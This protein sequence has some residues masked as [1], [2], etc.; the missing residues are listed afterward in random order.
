MKK[1]QEFSLVY[2][3][4]EELYEKVNESYSPLQDLIKWCQEQVKTLN[5]QKSNGEKIA[6]LQEAFKD[7]DEMMTFMDEK[8]NEIEE[9]VVNAD[10]VKVNEI[11]EVLVTVRNFL[12]DMN[13]MKDLNLETVY[14]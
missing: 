4:V 1:N 14:L 3:D 6:D 8:R 7:I 5:I 12:K 2:N 13:H 9:Y 11:C 10:L